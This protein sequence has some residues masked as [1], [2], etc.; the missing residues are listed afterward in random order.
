MDP[1]VVDV[2][3]QRERSVMLKPLNLGATNLVFIDDRDIAIANVTIVVC[4][5]GAI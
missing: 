4:N 1:D 5:A 2:Q 3:T